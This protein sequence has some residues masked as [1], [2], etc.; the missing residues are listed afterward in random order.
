[1]AFS[2]LNTPKMLGKRFLRR[3]GAQRSSPT[4]SSSSGTRRSS[5]IATAKSPRG[6]V[7]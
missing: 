7:G 1:M 6:K 5:R 4:P 2:I 3:A